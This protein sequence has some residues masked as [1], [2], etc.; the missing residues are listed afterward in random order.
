MFTLLPKS[1][2]FSFFLR[3]VFKATFFILEV[4]ATKPIMTRCKVPSSQGWPSPMSL[5]SQPT[6][7]KLLWLL[8]LAKCQA[9]EVLYDWKVQVCGIVLNHFRTLLA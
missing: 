3:K 5:T 8:G 1:L 2:F 9:A 6:G 4:V 7:Y